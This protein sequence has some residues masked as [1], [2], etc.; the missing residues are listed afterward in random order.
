MEWKLTIVEIWPLSSFKSITNSYS[1]LNPLIPFSM[2]CATLN[3]QVAA[4]SADN[5]DMDCTSSIQHIQQTSFCSCSRSSDC[6]IPE[7]EILEQEPENLVPGNEQG[8]DN[9]SEQPFSNCST[10]NLAQAI[11]LITKEL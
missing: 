8:E 4:S 1:P 7:L 10:V 2:P 9:S 6:G 5:I 3:S 11:M